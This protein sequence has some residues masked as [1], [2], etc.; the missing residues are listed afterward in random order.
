M[1][2]QAMLKNIVVLFCSVLFH[3]SFLFY[4]VCVC[5]HFDFDFEST[6][7]FCND[8]NDHVCVL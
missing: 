1:I 8:T 3:F 7:L 6:E 2:H 4:C 5:F